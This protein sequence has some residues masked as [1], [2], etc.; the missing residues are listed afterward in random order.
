MSKLEYTSPTA[1][2]LGELKIDSL[3][4]NEYVKDE[5]GSKGQV[6]QYIGE[7]KSFY[8]A[9]EIPSSE[10]KREIEFAAVFSSV[11]GIYAH[12]IYPTFRIY[13]RNFKLIKKEN[14]EPKFYVGGFKV[15][16]SFIMKTTLPSNAHYLVVNG[17]P[18]FFGKPMQYASTMVSPAQSSIVTNVSQSQVPIGAGGPF[19]IRVSS[20]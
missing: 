18:H 20:E 19:F 15:P 17:D 3:L 10:H 16:R 14:L 2:S 1:K 9:Y 12:V 8:R 5:L 11:A 6:Y 4:L 7:G 13:D